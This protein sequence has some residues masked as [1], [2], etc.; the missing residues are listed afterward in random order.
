[1]INWIK[2]AKKEIQQFPESIKENLADALAQLDRGVVLSLPLSRPMPSLGKGVHELRIKERSGQY[3]IIYY[4]KRK[5]SIWIVHGFKKTTP[6]TPKKAIEL[7]KKR[8]RE[9]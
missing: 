3:R 6:Q 2:A 9:I 8:I 4:I 7:A 5:D 1:M